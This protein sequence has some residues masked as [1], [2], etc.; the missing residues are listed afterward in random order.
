M[1]YITESIC[2][3]FGTCK[4]TLSML[5]ERLLWLFVIALYWV[6]CGFSGIGGVSD[7]MVIEYTITNVLIY[8]FIAGSA[9]LSVIF[10]A[11]VAVA[12]C[13]FIY[14]ITV[15]GLV[16]NVKEFLGGFVIFKCKTKEQ[17]HDKP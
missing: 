7:T 14:D 12:I 16:D 2:A 15:K 6:F 4:V 5:A 1:S 11:F 17:K 3:T 13:S 8:G 10:L 9:I